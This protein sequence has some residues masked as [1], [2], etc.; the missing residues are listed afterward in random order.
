MPTGPSAHGHPAEASLAVTSYKGC[1]KSSQCE[2][3]FFGITV[4]PENYMGSKR[5][6]CQ[7]DGCNQDPLPGKPQLSP[8]LESLPA[9]PSPTRASCE[10]LSLT[11]A[12]TRASVFL[13]LSLGF[14]SCKLQHPGT[15][16]VVH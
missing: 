14:F 12:V 11:C 13:A 1:A 10:H 8:M 6:C 7:K 5:R 4:N 3:G 2:S 9:H 15:S 16:L